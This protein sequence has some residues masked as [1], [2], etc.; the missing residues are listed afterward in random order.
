[1]LEASP[2]GISGVDV[3]VTADGVALATIDGSIWSGAG[4]IFVDGAQYQFHRQGLTGMA[5]TR[6]GTAIAEASHELLHRTWTVTFGDRSIVLRPALIVG[7]TYDVLEDLVEVGDVTPK[8]ILDRGLTANL[9][10]EIPN[11]VQ[12]FIVY[13]V[14]TVWRRRESGSHS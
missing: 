3:E 10:G 7:R 11:P 14:L 1:M 12:V 9:P 2:Q 8:G 13:V 4:T 6:D 5:L